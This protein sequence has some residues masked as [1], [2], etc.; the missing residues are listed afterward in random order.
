MSGS[1]REALTSALRDGGVAQGVLSAIRRTADGLGRVRLMEVCGTHTVAIR[2]SGIP[3]LLPAN[4]EL[5]SGPGCPVCVTPNH[6]VDHAVALARH[7]RL[8]LATFGDMV[9]VPGSSASLAAVRAEGADVRVVY[10]PLDAVRIAE[11]EPNREVVF[12]GVGFET[13][14]PTVAV[15]LEQAMQIPNFS[16]LSAHKLVPPALAALGSRSD[17]AVQGL[18]CPGHVST[19]IGSDAYRPFARDVHVPCVVAGFEPV[20]VLLAVLMILK[21][22]QSGRAEVETEYRCAVDAG[23]NRQAQAAMHRV[24]VPEDSDWRGLGRIAASGLGIAP[25]F[26]MRD[27]ATRFQVQVEPERETPGCRCGEVLVGALAPADC[28]RFGSVCT[29]ETPLGPC[30]VS[31]EGACSAHYRFRAA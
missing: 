8:I 14:A 5:V 17:F 3:A 29:P 10:S 30:M 21:Q 23:G 22:V 20:D 26:A 24:F 6:T 2:K 12:F 13:T 16:V 25:A 7:P 31:S 18:I 27:A 9:R 4:V 1:M 15:A 28:G 11:S 19:V